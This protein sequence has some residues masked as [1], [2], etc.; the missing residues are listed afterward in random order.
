MKAAVF[1]T[2]PVAIAMAKGLTRLGH[3][4]GKTALAAV[5]AVPGSSAALHVDAARAAEMAVVA[6]PWGGTQNALQLAGSANLAGKLVIDVTNPVD[7][8]SGKPKLALGFPDSAGAQVQ[9]WLPGAQVVKAFNTIGA[10]RFVDPVFDDGQPDMF[11]AGGDESA[12]AAVSAIVNGFGWRSAIDLGGIEQ[13]YLIEALAMTWIV[14][15]ASTGHWA[16]GFSLL[17][18]K[19]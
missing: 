6:T 5:A 4:A 18:A 11:I 8:S 1:G 2:G 3:T 7:F 14:Y 16:H 13:S 19:Q 12:K 9:A 15:G 10:G 17:G